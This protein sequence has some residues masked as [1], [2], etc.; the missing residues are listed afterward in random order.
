M[1]RTWA[2]AMT[3]F[4]ACGGEDREAPPEVPPS[5]RAIRD[6]KEYVDAHVA[7][8]AEAARAMCEAAPAPDDDG[9]SFEPDRAA[10]ESMRTEWRRARVEYE[11]IEGAIAILF[12]HIDRAVDGRYEHEAELRR[13]DDPFDDRGFVGMHAIERILWSGSIPA[14]A[15]AFERALPG[16]VEP[17]TPS[18]A[19]EAR[20]FRERL[21]G[22]LV[23]DIETMRGELAPLA[24]DA[25]TAWRG[26]QG[27]VEEQSEKVLLGAT[28]QDESRYAENTLADMRANL[29]GGRAVLAAY[30]AMIEATPEAR[31]RRGDIH[32]RMRELERAYAAI[33]TDA[34]PAVPDGF[35]PDA[36][37]EEHLA[38][39]YGRLFTLLSRA[40][41]P[42]VD[43]SL[44]HS[45]R[46]TGEA[47]GIPPLGR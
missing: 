2:L 38:T 43:G 46:S 8:L 40:S 33:G 41:D 24:L 7:A 23:R 28:G 6:V 3:L 45:L 12:P 5:E 26:I 19:T 29:E 1:R 27:S 11:R 34:L 44:A 16:Y 13:D 30:D 25:A 20:S 39:A 14:P 9:W 15:V 31:S 4:F 42:D 36:P 37:S 47:M 17:R 32:R 22:R 18:S 35:D 10:V 21:C